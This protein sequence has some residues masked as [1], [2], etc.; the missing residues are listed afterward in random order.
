MLENMRAHSDTHTGKQKDRQ[1]GG[2]CSNQE[3]HPSCSPCVMWIRNEVRF[4]RFIFQPAL[5]LLC[6]FPPRLLIVASFFLR[7]VLSSLLSSGFPFLLCVPD[8]CRRL[9][10]PCQCCPMKTKLCVLLFVCVA[11][12][13][14]A[15]L[16]ASGR[17]TCL[18]HYSHVVIERERPAASLSVETDIVKRKVL[19]EKIKN[20]IKYSKH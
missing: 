9:R 16:G 5:F 11:V 12:C 13:R 2:P 1:T 4:V 17:C 8:V 19:E 15:C 7:F 20:H 3:Q 14:L 18:W 10:A 6:F